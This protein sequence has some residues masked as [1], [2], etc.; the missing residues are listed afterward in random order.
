[1]SDHA[2]ALMEMGAEQMKKDRERIKELESV[3]MQY[4]LA[5]PQCECTTPD[6]NEEAARIRARAVLGMLT[7]RAQQPERFSNRF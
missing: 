4:L 2:Q 7:R 5:N 1:M 3:L 6:C